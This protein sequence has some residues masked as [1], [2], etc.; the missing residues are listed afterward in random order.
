MIKQYRKKPIIIEAMQFKKGYTDWKDICK[1]CGKYLGGITPLGLPIIKTI[2][3][4]M[5]V[6]DKDYII[7][8]IA[9]EIYPCKENIFNQTYDEVE[10]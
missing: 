7:K 4:D 9:G 10:E 3:G 6:S 8:G 5:I 2:E 1:F